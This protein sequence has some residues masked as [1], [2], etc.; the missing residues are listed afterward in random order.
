MNLQGAL[1]FPTH[2]IRD[3]E[4]CRNRHP[5]IDTTWRSTK[6]DPSSLYQLKTINPRAEVVSAQLFT[7]DGRF[8]G[9]RQI[10]LSEAHLY[11]QVPEQ[12]LPW[13]TQTPPS[14]EC[15]PTLP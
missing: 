15:A 4:F 13:R 6:D 8:L 7:S 1:Y 3:W 11:E 9:H 12:E 10:K 5:L 14:I 2:D